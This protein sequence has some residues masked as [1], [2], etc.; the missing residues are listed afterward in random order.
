MSLLMFD[1]GRVV[2]LTAS[3]FELGPHAGHLALLREAKEN[4][5]YLVVAIQVDPSKDRPEKNKPSQSIAE[6]YFQLASCRHVDE[7]IP[8]ETEKDLYNLICLVRPNIRFLGSDYADRVDYT[9]YDLNKKLNIS[10]HLHKRLHTVS[11]SAIRSA[12]YEL[13]KS[14]L[15]KR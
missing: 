4:C 14:K 6:R 10:V 1:R 13:E 12:V 3:C 5:Q 2:G 8:Y 9:G 11:S 15:E 7:I